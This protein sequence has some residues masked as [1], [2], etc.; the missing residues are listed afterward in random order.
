M[1]SKA[2]WSIHSFFVRELAMLMLT[3]P[4]VVPAEGAPGRGIGVAVGSGEARTT[5]TKR[6]NAPSKNAGIGLCI[7][8]PLKGIAVKAAFVKSMSS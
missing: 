5:Q 2:A 1:K 6:S 4:G 8:V 7:E 3:A